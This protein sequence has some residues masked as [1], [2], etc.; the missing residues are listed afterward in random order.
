MADDGDDDE[1]QDE[2]SGEEEEDE[3]SSIKKVRGRRRWEVMGSWDQ[4]EILR[5]ATVK[6]EE[7]GLVEWPSAQCPPKTIGLWTL[8]HAYT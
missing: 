3:S 6:M 4:T 8:C 2:D 1:I 7:S 5:I